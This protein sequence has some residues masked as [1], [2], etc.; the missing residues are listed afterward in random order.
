MIDYGQ[1]LNI[2][3]IFDSATGLGMELLL[4]GS[5]ISNS[6]EIDPDNNLI[7]SYLVQGLSNTGGV[8]TLRRNA[9][10]RECMSI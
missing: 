1:Y 3:F 6:P 5:Q 4:N 8:Y 9:D 7:L 2:S 10:E